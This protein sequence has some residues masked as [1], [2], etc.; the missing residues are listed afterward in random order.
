MR[1]YYRVLKILSN[2]YFMLWWGGGEG[3][4]Q[5]YIAIVLVMVYFAILIPDFLKNYWSLVKGSPQKI[6][7]YQL[8][9]ASI[10]L[11]IFHFVALAF[12]IASM[13]RPESPWVIFFL[14][15]YIGSHIVINIVSPVKQRKEM[16]YVGIAL[17]LVSRVSLLF[18]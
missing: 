9:L 1:I 11:L 5:Q 10:L 2:V 4:M 6:L 3:V 7:D 8:R 15:V 12:M 16:V 14:F 17:F 13:G 18:V